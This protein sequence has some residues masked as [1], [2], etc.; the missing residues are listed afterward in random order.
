MQPH[1]REAVFLV[2]VSVV[3]NAASPNPGTGAFGESIY[4]APFKV[5]TPVTV[6]RF[7]CCRVLCPS[8][9]VCPVPDGLGAW[10]VSFLCVLLHRSL[11]LFGPNLCLPI[12]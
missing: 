9:V 11:L 4:G 5:P 3:D 10:A 8:A 1:Y 12:N 2:A 7:G 6:A